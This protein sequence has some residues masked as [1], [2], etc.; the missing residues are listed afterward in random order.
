MNFKFDDVE[1]Q[2]EQYTANRCTA[3]VPILV[4]EYVLQL[5]ILRFTSRPFGD[6]AVKSLGLCNLWTASFDSLA[7]PIVASASIS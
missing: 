7:A 4:V 5:P 2:L 3:A 1:L 6:R